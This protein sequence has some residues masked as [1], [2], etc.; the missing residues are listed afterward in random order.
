MTILEAIAQMQ[1]AFKSAAAPSVNSSDPCG[2][3]GDVP[4]G[5]FATLVVN[6]PGINYKYRITSEDVLWTARM[7]EGEAGGKANADNFA[8][9]WA[10]L[11]R[12]ALLT[13][14]QRLKGGYKSFADFIRHYS[15]P[16]QAVLSYGSAKHHYLNPNFVKLGGFYPGTTVPRGQLKNHLELQKKCWSKLSPG[17]RKAAE[18][19]MRGEASNPIGL[20]TEFANTATYYYRE[21]KRKP[22]RQEWEE[23]TRT[24]GL[25]KSVTRDSRG[26]KVPTL[27]RKGWIW[28][29]D[30]AGLDQYGQNTF[31]VRS[32]P[33][34]G[35][36]SRI[37]I[38][39]LPSDTVQ[40]VPARSG[41]ESVSR[42]LEATP[43]KPRCGE[44]P[45]VNKCVCS[46]CIE[47][48]G[49]KV[50]ERRLPWSRPK[51]L[52]T[53]PSDVTLY[54]NNQRLDREASEAFQRMYTSA[55]EEA[56]KN[57]F[58]KLVSGYREYDY[59]ANA[60]SGAL[61]AV[62]RM[63][64]C[65]ESELTCLRKAMDSVNAVL[66]DSTGTLACNAWESRF[67]A[68]VK[69]RGCTVTCDPAKLNWLA[70]Q[71]GMSPANPIQVAIRHKRQTLAPAT[72]SP[73][74]T[75]RALDL[76]LGKIQG[77]KANVQRQRGTP[78]YKW[79]ACNASRFGF[80]P[81][82]REP[83]HWEYNPPA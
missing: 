33:V 68:E 43:S 54:K 63:L 31:F 37:A 15:T 78:T 20:A 49:C 28:I 60:W 72:A 75:G 29:G 80:Y 58:L 10:M 69:R 35:D 8:V 71:Y 23:Y 1:S 74:G 83:W 73:H 9:V 7:M 45:G 82:N 42:E 4:K 67:A 57:N 47:A 32:R 5:E 6:R 65:P 26:N 41:D 19:V 25:S 53:V 24:F 77:D 62:F 48:A 3:S 30:R 56:K 81:Y 76:N 13:N 52:V 17:A 51:E 66:K 55:P 11:N 22:S 21:H 39:E 36:P 40:L 61:V 64:G 14:P 38:S 70:K 18:T 27:D 16:L 79:L 34:S 50:C 46:G 44:G 12:W 59:D 2:Q